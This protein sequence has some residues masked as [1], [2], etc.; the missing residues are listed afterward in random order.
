MPSCSALCSEHIRRERDAGRLQLRI[1][2]N[3]QELSGDVGGIQ[4]IDRE[5]RTR[6]RDGKGMQCWRLIKSC[7]W[8]MVVLAYE[9]KLT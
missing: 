8:F 1:S 3:P 4:A 2:E 6:R 9:H 7:A 5:V